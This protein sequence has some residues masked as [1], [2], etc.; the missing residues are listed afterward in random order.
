MDKSLKTYKHVKVH[1][2]GT[3][4]VDLQ[5]NYGVC[6]STWSYLEALEASY[7]RGWAGLQAGD[8]IGRS[9]TSCR[10]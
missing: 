1:G 3:C 4:S 8:E 6:A 7:T 2:N 10:S 5:F 9:S